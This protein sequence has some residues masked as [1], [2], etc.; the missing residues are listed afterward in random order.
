MIEGAQLLLKTVELI[1]QDNVQPIPQEQLMDGITQLK[2]APRIFKE[3]CK[4]NWNKNVTEVYNFIRGLSPYP[5][6]WTNI[7]DS[8]KQKTFNFVKIY[9]VKPIMEKHQ[10]PAGTLVSD[11]KN[12]IKVAVKDGF[13]DILKLQLPGKKVLD[14]KNFINGYKPSKLKIN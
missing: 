11:D 8:E 3:D 7:F 9:S 4:I 12:F 14:I 1:E 10:L 13:I 6:A 2:T 5:G